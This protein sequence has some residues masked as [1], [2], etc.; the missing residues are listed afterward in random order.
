MGGVSWKGPIDT[1]WI[2]H[3]VII[4]IVQN[5]K[6]KLAQF[7]CNCLIINARSEAFSFFILVYFSA[8]VFSIV[9]ILR[10]LRHDAG[11]FSYKSTWTLQELFPLIILVVNVKL[12]TQKN[13]KAPN[14][15]EFKNLAHK[16]LME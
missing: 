7:C 15:C 3:L 4:S 13:I 9:N 6:L 14:S 1:A 2:D 16:S 12:N 10:Q 8:H 11:G 5:E